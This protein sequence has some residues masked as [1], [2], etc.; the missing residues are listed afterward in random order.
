MTYDVWFT[1]MN[2]KL[3]FT[4]ADHDG[5]P[6]NKTYFCESVGQA[7][8]WMREHGLEIAQVGICPADMLGI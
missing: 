4:Y 3:V 2:A 5:A 1:R 7:L 6:L 8:A